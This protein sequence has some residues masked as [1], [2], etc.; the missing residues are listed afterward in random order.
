MFCQDSAFLEKKRWNLRIKIFWS[1]LRQTV[2]ILFTTAFKLFADIVIS[3]IK[4]KRTRCLCGGSY[5]WMKKKKFCYHVHQNGLIPRPTICRLV[6]VKFCNF[7]TVNE[8][9]VFYKIVA[10]SLDAS[11][12][13]SVQFHK[14]VTGWTILF[15]MQS[16]RIFPLV[17]YICK[18]R[19]WTGPQEMFKHAAAIWIFTGEP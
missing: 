13:L 3:Q 12:I 7:W 8:Y 10:W 9:I 14:F 2:V 11:N 6:L 19:C 5:I 18:S 1:W 16:W 17:Q 15:E 4:V